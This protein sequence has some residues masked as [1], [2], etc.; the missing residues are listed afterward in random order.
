LEKERVSKR[1]QAKS[2]RTTVPR[3]G[4]SEEEK[5]QWAAA[6]ATAERHRQELLERA[7]RGR[8]DSGAAP[9]STGT[10]S[11]LKRS[12]S[13]PEPSTSSTARPKSATPHPGQTL[14]L[15]RLASRSAAERE[16]LRDARVIQRN[17]VYVTGLAPQYARSE[18]LSRP[19]YFGRYGEV[20][21]VVV[22][23]QNLAASNGRP[24]SAS[25]YITFRTEEQAATAVRSVTGYRLDSRV[26]K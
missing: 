19:E 8:S 14:A 12:A 16:E 18:T 25:A 5:A 7:G 6:T 26:L 4:L 11:V 24:P 10:A 13:A 15:T 1:K 23:K 21:K 17:L 20:V 9:A 2:K 22:N 3:D